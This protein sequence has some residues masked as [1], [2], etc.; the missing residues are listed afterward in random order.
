MTSILHSAQ[1]MRPRS[2]S[3][4]ALLALVA[5]ALVAPGA[6]GAS[7]RR[8]GDVQGT[9][10]APQGVHAIALSCRRARALARSHARRSGRG[11]RC[12]LAKPSCV[13]DGYRCRRTFFGNSGTRVRCTHEA[14]RVR[15]FY[16]V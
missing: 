3:V 6:T 9:A 5:L 12:D 16:G 13:L 1:D 4:L 15:F 10:D 2:L 7:E 14:E 8:C 11:E